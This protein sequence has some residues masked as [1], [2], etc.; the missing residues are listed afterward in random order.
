ML[1]DPFIVLLVNRQGL[2]S[3]FCENCDVQELLD[4][5]QK[6][7]SGTQLVQEIRKQAND[8]Q[9]FLRV[10]CRVLSLYSGTSHNML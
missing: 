1:N 6:E 10:S 8:V 4:L 7:P 3:Y 9:H 5:K 2:F